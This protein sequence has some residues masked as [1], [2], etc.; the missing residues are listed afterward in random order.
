V[1]VEESSTTFLFGGSLRVSGLGESVSG[2]GFAVQVPSRFSGR[3][4]LAR[5]V[6]QCRC[7]WARCFVDLGEVV[8]ELRHPV[9]GVAEFFDAAVGDAQLVE[10]VPTSEFEVPRATRNSRLSRPVR[11]S[12]K[13]FA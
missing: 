4:I 13:R 2:F 10:A 9:R 8:G 6:E 12:L 1:H 11:N 7:L 5:A 3:N